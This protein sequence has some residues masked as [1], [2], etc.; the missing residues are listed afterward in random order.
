[1]TVQTS[2]R[3]TSPDAWEMDDEI[4]LRKYLDILIKRWRE[5]IVITIAV[6]V[7]AAATVLILRF[8][9]A[10]TYEADANV[11]I[12]RTQTQVNLDERFTTS[13][14]EVTNADVNS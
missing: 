5:I 12:V 2:E 4:D 8:V 1:M 11:A 6:V 9:Q 10:P 13:S 7:V 14:G 3:P